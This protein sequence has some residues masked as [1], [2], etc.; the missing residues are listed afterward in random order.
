MRI[1]PNRR[2]V[3]VPAAMMLIPLLP[4][5]LPFAYYALLRLAVCGA[6][7]F[8]AFDRW[9]RERNL[10]W[11]L[12]GLAVIYNPVIP[13]HLGRQALWDPINIIGALLLLFAATR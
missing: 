12:A 8:L 4:L 13:L 9:R 3:I 2:W 1:A 11:A 7:G 6:A 5:K 10:A